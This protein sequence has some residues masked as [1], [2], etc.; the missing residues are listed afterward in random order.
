MARNLEEREVNQSV[1]MRIVH[2]AGDGRFT[3]PTNTVPS[4]GVVYARHI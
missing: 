2:E 4:I 3:H 1:L